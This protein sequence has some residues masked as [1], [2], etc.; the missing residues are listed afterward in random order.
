MESDVKTRKLE[1][2]KIPVN[3]N[4]EKEPPRSFALANKTKQAAER[5]HIS[6]ATK[7]FW[8]LMAMTEEIPTEASRITQNKIKKAAWKAESRK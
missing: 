3:T 5:T 4:K 1:N 6:A 2:V 8:T 7:V